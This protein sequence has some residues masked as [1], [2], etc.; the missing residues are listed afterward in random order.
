MIENR[1]TLSGTAATSPALASSNGSGVPF[2]RFRLASTPRRFDKPSERWVDGDTLFV[3]VQAWRSLAEHVVSSV[4]KGD[5]LI[6]SGRLT[7]RNYDT[8]EGETRTEV[9]IEAT[10]VGHDLNRGE[11]SFRRVSAR[12][13]G[14]TGDA[15]ASAEA[16][17]DL[18]VDPDTGE[19]VVADG[20]DAAAV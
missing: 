19:V 17:G 18:T 2:T 9:C 8:K 10:G 15:V 6:V 12:I 13:D 5:P 11:T 7:V 16:L 4:R 14:S 3:T 1:I 20:L